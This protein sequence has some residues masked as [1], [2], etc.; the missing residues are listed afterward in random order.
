MTNTVK[1]VQAVI[2]C[3]NHGNNISKV[4]LYFDIVKY[5][6]SYKNLIEFLLQDLR[7]VLFC[8][9]NLLAV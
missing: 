2:S 5:H 9:L 8:G 3:H 6:P 7:Y 4:I 1:Y